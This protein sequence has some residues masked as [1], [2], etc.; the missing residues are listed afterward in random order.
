[1]DTFILTL[2]LVVII[3]N[4]ILYYLWN[5]KTRRMSSSNIQIAENETDA[6]SQLPAG[7]EPRNNGEDK[8]AATSE[9]AT[10]VVPTHK[11]TS[12]ISQDSDTPLPLSSISS[13]A[14]PPLPPSIVSY[15]KIIAA[16][17][18]YVHV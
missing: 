5:K 13:G 8:Q 3:N 10:A 7:S 15:H 11:F 6:D 2:L 9:T 18:R 12:D 4:A 16:V 1:M 17:T 14:P